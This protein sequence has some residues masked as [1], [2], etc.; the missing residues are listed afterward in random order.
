[1]RK[2]FFLLIIVVAPQWLNA[3]V[4][5]GFSR[6]TAEYISELNLLFTGQVTE[7][8][9]LKYTEFQA[10]WK[11]LSFDRRQEIMHLSLLLQNK[12]CA[13]N[14]HYITFI[15]IIQ[16]FLGNGKEDMGYPA[17]YQGFAAFLETNSAIW[18]NI[19][20]VQNSTLNLLQHQV[21]FKASGHEWRVLG[22]NFSFATRDDVLVVDARNCE[23]Q[24]AS[25]GDSI[26]L[27]EVNGYYDVL[28]TSFVGENGTVYWD[29]HGFDRNEVFARF[30]EFT[31]NCT[32]GEYSV[33]SAILVYK[34][35]FEDRV[36]GTLHDRHEPNNER[37]RAVYPRFTTYLE[38]F[39]FTNLFPGVNYRGGLIINGAYKEGTVSKGKNA[40]LDFYNQDTLRVRISLPSVVFRQD[41]IQSEY[42]EA[43]IYIEQDSIYHPHVRMSYDVEK[44][45]MRLTKT[46]DY[47]S[48]GP[49]ADSYHRID[50]NFQELS[51]ERT[52]S[53]IKMQAA[54][55][56]TT[57]NALFESYDFFNPEFYS[58][59]Q[60][61]D[62]DHPL[63]MLWR[64][65]ERIGSTTFTVRAY[66]RNLG[67]DINSVRHQ[68]MELTR[69]GFVYLYADTDEVYLRPKLFDFVD[70]DARL[71]D[72][73]VIRFVSRTNQSLVNA[74]LDLNTKDLVING[75]PNI[76][77]SN[78][79]NVRLIPKGNKI[80][81]K[82]NRDFQ[83]DG[84][85]D[86][87][88]FKFYGSN[89]FFEY[90][91][92]SINLQSIDSL[93]ISAKT[94]EVDMEGRYITTKLDN[95][96]EKITGELLID[97]PFN[98]SGIEDYPEYPVFTSLETSYVYFD[99]DKIQ[100]GVYTRDRFYFA[101]DPFSI[102][103]LDN[104]RREAMKMDGTFTSGGIL[105][106]M[107]ME[108][109]LRPDNS[110][111]FYMTTPEAGLPIYEGNATFHNDIE[112]SSRG[113]HGYGSM[114]YINSTTW[115]DDFLFHP[116][117]LIT[118]SRRF[119]NRETAE[120]VSLLSR[121]GISEAEDRL[122]SYPHQLSGGQRQR[123]MIA[124]AIACK[125]KLLVADEPTTA[126][127]V[128]VQ[129]QIL[130]LLKSLQQEF[131]MAILLITHNLPLVR[132]VADTVHIMN[133]GRIIESGT[134]GD[135]FTS[136]KQP[137]TQKLLQSIPSS[138]PPIKTS[139][140]PLISIEQLNC[141]FTLRGKRKKIFLKNDKI[142]Q[143]VDNV[144]L[145]IPRGS[146]CGIVGES[147]SGKTTLGMAILR[148][149]KSTGKIEFEGLQLNSLKGK[150]LRP[151]RKQI[152]VVFQDPFSSLSPRLTIE[153]VVAEG[154]QV[155]SP[156]ITRKERR[157]KVVETLTEV[158]LEPEMAGRYPHEFSGGQ[159]QRI[160]IARSLIL[161]PQFLV[162]DE[163]TS[164]LDMTIQAQIIELLASLQRKYNMTYLFISHDLLV[165]KALADYIMVMQQGR[166]VEAGPAGEIFSSPRQEYTKK[167]FK[168]AYVTA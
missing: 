141:Q 118:T 89:F 85:I 123:V 158:G 60:G 82:R 99:E 14:P 53:K 101:L 117:S 32:Q 105:P 28:N 119:L 30:G 86:A 166:V 147:G 47:N 38:D 4:F 116:D 131:N 55:G 142:I 83:F 62:F 13:A 9:W 93:E 167:L 79:Q 148:M 10:T 108:M 135:I 29:R 104:F 124:M 34:G 132:S 157:N 52:G 72:Y 120:A 92:F 7:E 64:Y 59:L 103:S 98:K 41:F 76:Y 113:L 1:M 115:S 66:A 163:P 162:L 78:A 94:D 56:T 48:L 88:L 159:R 77:L 150:D 81:M 130:E 20:R 97:A 2:L 87:G 37:N 61:I 44:E 102:D 96:I 18:R 155:H 69:L 100:D 8:D 16:E 51:W 149:V 73:D 5:T 146:T 121:T 31:I 80:I 107:R 111:G 39:Q 156:E 70:A 106:E 154:L 67:V 165:V 22:D 109:S 128:T 140:P 137:Y 3:Q 110:L 151:L 161:R 24:C 168:A 143:A 65:S 11:D 122:N 145:K 164:A 40:I 17:W 160:A 57:G 43:F 58:Q 26:M 90:D 144:S 127:D 139:A 49:Y 153:E 74:E 114:D 134:A 42:A 46:K 75:I 21:L 15:K 50:M 125:P 12:K 91:R 36:L 126:L 19:T 136:P 25:P 23:L 112:M 129:L 138:Q 84:I 33:D 133:T 68:M 6:D 63:V 152:Q 95:A 54:L 45:L 35:L 71:R 27:S